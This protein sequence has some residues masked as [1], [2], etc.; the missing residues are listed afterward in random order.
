MTEDQPE[1]ITVTFVSNGG[2]QVGA[3]SGSN[4][5][6]ISLREKGGVPF[7]CGAGLCGTCRCLITAGLEHTDKVK[8]KE[9]KHLTEADLLAGYR[10]ACQTF[11]SGDVSVSWE[12][13]S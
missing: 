3:D 11:V 10:M 2:K 7:K 6:R 13:R 9:R 5:L 1:R 8:P 12:P 4:L